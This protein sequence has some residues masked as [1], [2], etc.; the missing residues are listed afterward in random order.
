MKLAYESRACGV[1]F[2]IL[3]SRDSER[4]FLLPSNICPIVPITFL[5]AGWRFSFVDISTADLFIDRDQCLQIV[6]ESPENYGGIMFVRTYGAEIDPG[7]FFA[8]LKRLQPSLL[9]IDDKCLCRP[10]YD[11]LWLDPFSDVTLFSTG[12]SKYVDLGFG[13][14]AFLN[15][16]VPYRRHARGF[17]ESALLEVTRRYKD[18]IAEHSPFKGAK[19]E[20]LD[21][22]EPCL[23]WHRY[24][25]SLL[26]TLSRT[27]Q[28]K[29]RINEIYSN[30]VPVEIQLPESFQQWRFNIRVSKA[31]RLV[32]RLFEANLFASRHYSSLGGIFFEGRFP[33]A[34]ELHES[35]VNL[36]NDWNFNETKA[37]LTTEIIL[38]HLRFVETDSSH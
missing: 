3:C 32:V 36:L 10:D 34:E 5:K 2:N 25:K 35:V 1:L 31:D 13:G 11:G 7:N 37:K 26:D 19:D 38:E 12:Y 17:A 8:E 27:E 9:I 15:D 14:F 23:S 4:P 20:W 16:S 22:S 6:S 24:R 28:H 21:L 30:A 33:Q 18:A 29:R